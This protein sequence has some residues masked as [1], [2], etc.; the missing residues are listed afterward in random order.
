ML[1][2]IAFNTGLYIQGFPEY[3]PERTGAPITSYNRMD[4]KPIL[5]HSNIYEPD[6]VVVV[7]DTILDAADVTCGLKET[8]SILINTSYSSDVIRKKLNNFK[9]K[10]YILDATK[11]AEE[12]IKA[13]F[14]NTSL[15]SGMIKILNLM[16]K[17]D[18][19]KFML[20]SF[21]H[22]FSKKPEVIEP[23]IRAVLRAYEELKEV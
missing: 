14:P 2:D 1:A 16:N 5:L 13:P 15:L 22:K 10:L 7:D 23:N 17:E 12:E 20:E 3:G 4:S 8:S 9:G 6:Y 11:I 19:E 18:L 21:K